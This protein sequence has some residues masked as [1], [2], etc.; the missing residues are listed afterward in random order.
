[1]PP[2][3]PRPEPT[4][5]TAPPFPWAALHA[6]WD[7][8]AARRAQPAR[9][10]SLPGLAGYRSPAEVVAAINRPGDPDRS[11]Q[12]LTD[13]LVTAGGDPL[14]A[15]AVL[16]AVLPGVR[17][18]VGRR[19]RHARSAGPWTG[20]DEIAADGISAAWDAIATRAGHRVD[21]PAAAIVRHV[22]D[23][24]RQDHR[25]WWRHTSRTAALPDHDAGGHP[26]G[27]AT[28][29]TADAADP[30]AFITDALR[31]GHIDRSQ[32]AV[33]VATGVLGYSVAD[34]ARRLH[35]PAPATYR[36]LAAARHALR[37]LITADDIAG[38]RGRSSP[39]D[40]TRHRHMQPA[41]TPRSSPMTTNAT[42]QPSPPA[43]P[44]TV[45]TGHQTRERRR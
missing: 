35:S 9:W 8:I 33:L 14:A 3:H 44:P 24:L 20:P 18:A 17:A 7:T 38:H 16:Q 32:A 28:A 37:P 27:T 23:R 45:A 15:R 41:Q 22:E 5:G 11:H 12:L 1:M 39:P 13:L 21:R 25:R 40:A 34:A 29:P 30:T 26:H 43:D 6:E 4:V 42:T 31:A 36:T 10:T 2:A 19:W